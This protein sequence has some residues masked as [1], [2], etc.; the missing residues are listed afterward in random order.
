MST[1]SLLD[2]GDE[3]V[4]F[5]RLLQISGVS[6]SL[7]TGSEKVFFSLRAA[8]RFALIG[9]DIVAVGLMG[10]L[11]AVTATGLSGQGFEI[12]GFSIPDPTARNVITLV[13]LVAGLFILKGGLGILFARWT[14]I[15]LA[16]VE[17][18]N[19]AKV[20]RFLFSGSLQRLRNYSRME[21]NF[22]IGQS[23]QATFSGV[24]GAM[25]TLVI[26]GVL[27]VSIFVMFIVVD[28]IAAFVI[29]LYFA[30]LVYLLQATT[31]KRYLES[32]RNIQRGAIDTGSTILEMVDGFR[33][34]AVL[35]KQ[36][37]FLSR[38]IEAK[39]LSARTGVTLQ[40]LKSLP[41][42]IAESGLIIG[43]LG[44]LVWQLSRG[45]LG[46]GLLAL[47]IFL[48][49]SFRMMGAI[50]PLQQIWNQ[51]RIS[52]RWVSAAQE[53]L[54]QLRDTPELL[55]A[56]IYSP[57]HIAQS[58]S[59]TSDRL[60]V[61]IELRDVSFRHL[62]APSQTIDSVSLSA[63]AGSFVAVVGPSGAGKTTLVDLILGLY[64][65][66]RGEVELD[67]VEPEV[68]R[69]ENPGLLSYVPQK[70]GLVT[71]SI[72]ENIALGLDEA[73]WD[74][75]EIWR[76]L[77]GAQL[78]EHVRTLDNGILTDLGPHSDSLSGGQIQRLGLARALYTSPQLI[79]LDEATSALDAA[80]EASIGDAIRNLGQKTTVVVIA[81]RL[82]TIQHADTVHV[83]ESGQ[84]IDSGT[85]S[86]VRKRVPMIEEY[87]KLMSFE[88]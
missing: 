40:L 17:V 11:G 48:A 44:F 15:F 57:T 49:G 19:S 62:N 20:A 52:Q 54:G 79:V 26:D 41:R 66:D 70:P 61:G 51:L 87:V 12:F 86:E 64:K 83:M 69:A 47:G 31:A 5:R 13:A 24:L 76:A 58:T 81:H 78:A 6:W 7:L 68:L 56:S 36:D 9:L 39:K 88:D 63:P 1:P 34:I 77:E 80:T 35:S 75:D 82:S 21:I 4:S 10:V 74:V 72:A 71:G 2:S 33:E 28:P 84:I 29:A 23:I 65:P 67:G 27:F 85:F 45:S 32:G 14:S 22:L 53:V 43:A 30:I 3:N 37:F 60:A 59:V 42:Y 50:L 25:T 16:Q 8:I 73:D 38:F 46:E 18:K 55:D